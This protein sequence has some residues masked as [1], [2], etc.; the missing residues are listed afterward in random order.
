MGYKVLG[1]AVWHGGKW[2][3]R[4]RFT[5]FSRKLA[6]AGLAAAVVAGLVV[7]QRQAA[8]HE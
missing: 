6:I 1:Y 8:A 2:Y 7:A 5:G 4:R 3:F